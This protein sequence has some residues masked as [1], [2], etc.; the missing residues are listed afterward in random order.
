MWKRKTTMKHWKKTI[1]ERLPKT[2][3]CS[4][5]QLEFGVY[6]VV[7]SFN[8]G[9]KATVLIFETLE[10]IPGLYTLQGCRKD[11]RK[12]IILYHAEYKSS[13]AVKNDE[14]WFLGKM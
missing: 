6:D 9:Y 3:Y 14:K 1:W 7:A 12:R 11:D 10:M 13:D 8:I 5:K 4:L 2:T